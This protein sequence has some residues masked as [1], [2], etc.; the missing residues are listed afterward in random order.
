VLFDLLKKLMVCIFCH[1][2]KQRYLFISK[3]FL[4]FVI[5]A[6]YADTKILPLIWV[7]SSLETMKSRFDA[8]KENL[9]YKVSNPLISSVG[10][11]FFFQFFL[12]RSEH[13]KSAE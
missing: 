11:L 8:Q 10:F 2:S 1:L 3:F 5:V 13:S 7:P 9:G 12:H 4:S 6:I